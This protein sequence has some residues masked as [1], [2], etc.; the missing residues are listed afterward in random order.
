MII[1]NDDWNFAKKSLGK[2]VILISLK[3]RYKH[4]AYIKHSIQLLLKC[5]SDN[6]IRINS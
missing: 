1:E 5:Y 4:T 3:T 2:N 6:A